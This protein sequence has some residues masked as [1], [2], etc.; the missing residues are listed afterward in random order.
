M[1]LVFT[2]AVLNFMLGF[3]LAVLLEREIALP[4]PVCG[5][6]P[7]H[8]GGCTAVSAR[9]PAPL[10]EV[11]DNL[12]SRWLELLEF[13]QLRV[14]TFSGVVFEVLKLELGF[15]LGSLLDMEDRL[16]RSVGNSDANAT[17]AALQAM[18]S[19]NQT[20]LDR[21]RQ[22]VRVVDENRD[23]LGRHAGWGDQLERALLDQAAVI[24][25]GCGAL[26][27]KKGDVKDTTH[28]VIMAEVRH[29][30]RLG[31]HLRDVVE[32]GR[33]AT[34][35][36]TFES[37]Q[38]DL[39]RDGTTG[40]RDR[41][42]IELAF[43]RWRLEADQPGRPLSAALIDLDQFGRLN[44]Q[45]STRVGDRVLKAVAGHLADLIDPDAE[46]EHV[47]RYG[48]Q[49]FFVFLE[50]SGP[51]EAAGTIERVRKRM[52]ATRLEHGGQ[53][54]AVS[55][56][57][58][59]AGVEVDDDTDAIFRRLEELIEKAKHAGGNRVELDERVAAR[60]PRPEAEDVP[61]H[62]LSVE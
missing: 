50:D 27:A 22:F 4:V 49:R 52:E 35:G 40:L 19:L 34:S 1:P 20:W 29:F 26:L 57:A 33:Q 55:I 36:E 13:H 59:V 17:D 54:Y 5:G 60:P 9:D 11:R 61:E 37:G 45:L 43:G 25:S 24:E 2:I 28:D 31:H 12:P 47:F 14:S 44:E 48:G 58:G 6:G 53:R 23:C 21:Q 18:V 32:A 30:I 16:R 7:R 38:E 3:A 10:D 56:R 46:R 62:V 15:Y 8:S 51:D 41:R 39:Q 42:A